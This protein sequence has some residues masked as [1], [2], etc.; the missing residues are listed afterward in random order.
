M[1]KIMIWVLWA[2]PLA[3]TSKAVVLTQ[4]FTGDLIDQVKITQKHIQNG[5]VLV[6]TAKD[7]R[8]A[9][10]VKRI[11]TDT[12]KMPQFSRIRP[13]QTLELLR[14]KEI[15]KTVIFLNN[16]IK[17]GLTSATSEWIRRIHQLKL[18]GARK[19]G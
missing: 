11:V 9:E 6:I 14:I 2:L 17:L 4:Q 1:K 5:T 3:V 18:E 12:I 13:N 8:V 7:P 19:P 15:H 10:R 16:G